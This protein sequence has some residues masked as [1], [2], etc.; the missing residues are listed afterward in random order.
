MSDAPKRNEADPRWRLTAQHV[1]FAYALGL[2]TV[3]VALGAVAFALLRSPDLAKALA[4]RAGASEPAVQIREEDYERKLTIM[5]WESIELYEKSSRMRRIADAVGKISVEWKSG[6][7]SNCTGT[8]IDMTH[9]LTAAHCIRPPPI[10]LES[11]GEVKSLRITMGYDG[12]GDFDEPFSR[13]GRPRRYE[14]NPKPVEYADTEKLDYAIFSAIVPDGD[15]AK[16]PGEVWEI[17]PLSTRAIAPLERGNQPLIAI[18]HPLSLTPKQITRYRCYTSGHRLFN[19][20]GRPIGHNCDTYQGSSGGPLFFAEEFALA[21]IH[22]GGTSVSAPGQE[23]QSAE[24]SQVEVPLNLFTPMTD[25]L[26]VSPTLW[27]IAFESDPTIEERIPEPEISR[28]PEEIEIVAVPSAI[29][30]RL[31]IVAFATEDRAKQTFCAGLALQ[32]DLVL[33]S[34]LCVSDLDRYFEA[35]SR[36]SFGLI[37]LDQMARPARGSN[38]PSGA[39]FK[40]DAGEPLAQ[41]PD[42]GFAILSSKQLKVGLEIARA[43]FGQRAIEPPVIRRSD[44]EPGEPLFLHAWNASQSAVAVRCRMVERSGTKIA[45]DCN[46]NS[47][48]GSTGSIVADVQGRAVAMHLGE[49]RVHRKERLYQVGVGLSLHS[50]ELA[51]RGNPDWSWIGF[52]APQTTR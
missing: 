17:A 11:T 23:E 1:L 38:A 48:V 14:L 39:W 8:L 36:G 43:A 46:E 26:A 40:I 20:S 31:G 25:M 13:D 2:F 9:V 49:F 50:L 15:G 37:A 19:E 12:S 32:N 18:H 5:K 21:G 3:I 6:N 41:S 47:V 4:A 33:T 29:V 42:L 51:W 24:A 10:D 44:P 22:K 7:V 52:D 34:H 16:A 27:L 28:S 35:P 30:P 45:Y